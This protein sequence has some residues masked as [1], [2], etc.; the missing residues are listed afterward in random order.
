[1]TIFGLGACASEPADER[2][3]LDV[4]LG[5][6]TP[7]EIVTR[8]GRPDYSVSGLQVEWH[9][10]WQYL[11]RRTFI[12]GIL[13]TMTYHNISSVGRGLMKMRT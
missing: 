6:I 13:A 12:Q 8:F 9:V 4:P 11:C 10:S 2:R 3:E 7:G 1:M 5:R